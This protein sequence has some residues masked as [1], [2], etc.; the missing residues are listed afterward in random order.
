MRITKLRIKN[1]FGIRELELDGKD[2]E[3]IGT[4]GA[5]KSSVIDAIRT[6]LTNKSNRPYILRN[7]ENEGEIY[8][9]TD[10]GLVI[11]RKKRTDQADYKS[12][13]NGSEVITSPESFLST[14]FT[15]LQLNPVSF[16][17]MSEK[18]QNQAILDLIEFAWDIPW[19]I[20]Q[21]GEVPRDVDY[22][23]NI[24]QV[25]HDIQSEN[26]YYF[27]HRQDINRDIKSKTAQAEGLA[28]GIPARF[29]A[30]H[31]ESFDLSAKYRE[32]AEGQDINGKIASAK[33]FHDSYN[34]KVRG[35]D[36][37]REIAVSALRSE[38]ESERNTLNSTISRLEAEIKAA[39][40]KLAGL[41]ARLDEKIAVVDAQR[42]ADIAKLDKD[43]GTASDYMSRTPVDTKSIQADIDT[44]EEMKKKL[45]DYNR[46]VALQD[47]VEKLTA[48]SD[49]L[50][51]KIDL[52]RKLPGVIL[53][54]AKLPVEGLSVVDGVPLVNGLPIR[55]LSEGEMLDLCV[56]VALSKPNGIQ[57]ILIDGAE[58]L[59]EVNRRHLYE[60]CKEKGVQV[61][62]SRTT[63]DPDLLV[64]AL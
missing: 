53:E 51:A 20:K 16:I 21:F 19:I 55:N 8:V 45:Y 43:M 4:N 2:V 13:K 1:V 47:E 27:K 26:G 31:W 54:S 15:P 61:I 40:E 18:E 32:L 63:D 34:D 46:M 59:S 24:L 22:D 60:K 48:E 62:A 42:E 39:K 56:N 5:G 33:M 28:S 14:L 52:A 7:G 57:L 12:V 9:E 10:T 25:L 44:A 41:D 37:K 30:A 58:K 49:E 17:Q 50:T 23:Q 11:N 3:L 38:T 64:T 29:D 6:A 35:I 36:G